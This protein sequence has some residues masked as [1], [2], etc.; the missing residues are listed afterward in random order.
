MKQKQQDIK[1]YTL[2]NINQVH[3][4]TIGRCGYC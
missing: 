4:E 1:N 2:I 3:T